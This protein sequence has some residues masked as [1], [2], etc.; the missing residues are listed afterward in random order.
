MSRWPL[1]AYIEIKHIF[2]CLSYV[3]QPWYFILAAQADFL[4]ESLVPC[5]LHGKALHYPPPLS[6]Q[7][8]SCSPW[9]LASTRGSGFAPAV[10]P[11]IR[12]PPSHSAYP[13][14]TPPA[15]VTPALLSYHLF[16]FFRFA[17]GFPFWPSVFMVTSIHFITYVSSV[18]R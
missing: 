18:Y 11:P 4:L 10:V 15:G 12:H 3:L 14:P 5:L 17:L 6:C 8:A 2:I 7:A 16:W 9:T 13:R 1:L